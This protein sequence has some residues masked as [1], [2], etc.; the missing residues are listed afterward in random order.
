MKLHKNMWPNK[1]TG[2]ITGP[3]KLDFLDN[4]QFPERE[5]QMAPIDNLLWLSNQLGSKDDLFPNFSCM[6]LNPN[7]FFQFEF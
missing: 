5:I 6:F 3:I 2:L 7:I 1:G 4:H